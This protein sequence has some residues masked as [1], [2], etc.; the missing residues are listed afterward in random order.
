MPLPS[1]SL[2]S[3]PFLAPKHRS[4]GLPFD[5]VTSQQEQMSGRH[6]R[7]RSSPGASLGSQYLGMGPELSSRLGKKVPL[8]LVRQALR[9]EAVSHLLAPSQR[10]LIAPLFGEGTRQQ[11]WR[12]RRPGKQRCQEMGRCTQSQRDPSAETESGEGA[13]QP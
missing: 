12:E 6:I 5:G 13:T 7:E 1:L 8:R 4:S 10:V 11:H 3:G 9:F 2:S